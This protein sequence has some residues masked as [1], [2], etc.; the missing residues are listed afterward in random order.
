[1]PPQCASP[2]LVRRYYSA[3]NYYRWWL[4]EEKPPS[5]DD[6]HSQA[7]KEVQQWRD[8]VAANSVAD[9][10]RHFQPQQLVKGMYAQFLPVGGFVPCN[11][12]EL[13][14][15]AQPTC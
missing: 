13:V 15:F 9:C 4:K 6:F 3:F 14:L 2:G 8:C 5:P 10:V 12:E 1:M 7:L 11:W